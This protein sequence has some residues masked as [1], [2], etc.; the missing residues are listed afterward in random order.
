MMKMGIHI[1]CI[2]LNL[3][4]N[5]SASGVAGGKISS[6]ITAKTRFTVA[7]FGQNT[8]IWPTRSSYSDVVL[9]YLIK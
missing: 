4:L 5:N 6:P 8:I 7:C 3:D 1:K 9:S 2:E